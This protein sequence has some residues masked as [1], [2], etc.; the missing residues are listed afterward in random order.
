MENGVVKLIFNN[1]SAFRE[2]DD[3]LAE[4][5]GFQGLY[6]NLPFLTDCINTLHT[7]IMY[8]YGSKGVNTLN[9]FI[10]AFDR[11]NVEKL[12]LVLENL[13]EDKNELKSQINRT[14]VKAYT[15]TNVFINTNCL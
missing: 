9:I 2:Q 12:R 13:F 6:M 4:V 1:L 11:E 10:D 15:D 7:I 8:G 5:Y 3:T 14:Y